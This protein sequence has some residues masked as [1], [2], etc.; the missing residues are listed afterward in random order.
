MKILRDT[1]DQLILERNPLLMALG[2]L[3][4][5]GGFLVAGVLLW[6]QEPGLA[7]AF[8]LISSL[9][10]TVFFIILVRRTQLILD[11]PRNL[12]ELR[13]RSVFGYE[14]Q[15]WPLS[16]LRHAKLQISTTPDSDG[17]TSKTYRPALVFTGATHPVTTV[18][19]NGRGNAAAVETINRW[20]GTDIAT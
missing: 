12:V 16:E 3:A 18:F 13:R 20:L 9:V 5:P 19:T 11:R 1:P 2:F 6:P 4:I 10:G 15:T 17:D 8:I 14:R 7:A